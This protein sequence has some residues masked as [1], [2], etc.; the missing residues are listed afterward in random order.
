MTDWQ[1]SCSLAVLRERALMLKDIREFFAARNVLEVETPVLGRR[2]T[3]DPAI[4]S[5]AAAQ[6]FLQTSPE[7]HMKRLLAAGAPSIYR[8]GPVF[9][10]GEAGR[11]HNAEFTML[12]WYRLE[13]DAAEL[14]REVAA[15][16]SVLLGSA[17]YRYQTC[18][19]VL[20]AR[21]G[22][23]A[24]TAAGAEAQAQALGL[25]ADGQ[26]DAT[27][28]LLAEAL[29][30]QPGRCFVTEF[31]AEK[32]ALAALND[33]GTAARFELIVNGI[34]VANGYLELRDPDELARRMA[35][36]NTQR[37]RRAMPAVAPDETLVA[38]HQH[39]LPPCAGVAVGVDRLFAL[40]QGLS[41]V[42]EAMAFDWSRA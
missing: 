32:A 24:A 9:R 37:A 18:A 10:A 29:S 25:D 19:E 11:W 5:I 22:A 39:G 8:L 33:N 7:H 30:A 4:D 6:R 1:P 17:E 27:D 21:F 41:S 38:A 26:D 23:A 34:E 28:L 3:T 14:M 12:E 13:F 42:A 31:P 16:V 40:Q 36:D 15:L 20:V 35:Q 2:T